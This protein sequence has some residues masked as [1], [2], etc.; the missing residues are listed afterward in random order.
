MS[1]D[2]RDIAPMTPLQDALDKL[3]T[4]GGDGLEFDVGKD[5]AGHVG[6]SVEASK[7]LGKGWSVAAAAQWAKDVG[8]AVMGKLKWTPKG[9]R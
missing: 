3:G 1:D 6:A 2:L 5:A 4:S 8:Y 7:E 9:S